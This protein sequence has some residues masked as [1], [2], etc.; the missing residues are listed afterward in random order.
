MAVSR[1]IYPS[2]ITRRVF[3]LAFFLSFF[4]Y[5]IIMI[6]G[7]VDAFVHTYTYI[8][9]I[10]LK[11]D[12]PPPPPLSLFPLP[13]LRALEERKERRTADNDG[14]YIDLLFSLS[15]PFMWGID[16]MK[17]CPVLLLYPEYPRSV[18]D[19]TPCTFHIQPSS[20]HRRLSFHKSIGLPTI[21]DCCERCVALTTI[22]ATTAMMIT[23]AITGMS[24]HSLWMNRSSCEL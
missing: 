9:Y 15:L 12:P 5:I 24:P 23:T 1:T 19:T 13:K 22:V 17:T 11:S 4:F 8:Y 21:R 3:L 14:N 6:I 20:L 7:I 10:L 2:S 16:C 18:Y